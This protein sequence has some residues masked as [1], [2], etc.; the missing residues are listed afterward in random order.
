M[1][2]PDFKT[3]LFLICSL[4]SALSAQDLHIYF[5]A[6]PDNGKNLVYVLNGDT[7]TIPRSGAEVRFFPCRQ[8]QQLPVQA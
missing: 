8:F 4:N 1:K 3:A 5:N 2:Y 7:L 6:A